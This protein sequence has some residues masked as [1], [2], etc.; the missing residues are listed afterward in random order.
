MLKSLLQ[1]NVWNLLLVSATVIGAFGGFPEP[2][3]VFQNLA[4]FQIVQWS[5]VFI[6]AY[7][8]G[9][10]ADPIFALAATLI[11]MV[12]YKVVRAIE[13]NDEDELL[14]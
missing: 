4:S 8:G 10:G 12:L 3:K 9:A 14:K 5:L 11:T 6:L 13:N 1:Y 2:P 7:Q